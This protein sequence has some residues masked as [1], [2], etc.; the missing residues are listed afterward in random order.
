MK[1]REGF[2]K[3]S[4]REMHSY[5]SITFAYFR[6]VKSNAYIYKNNLTLAV[7]N[8]CELERAY[9]NQIQDDNR[10]QRVHHTKAKRPQTGN[11]SIKSR[12]YN[13]GGSYH[14]T[15]LF[16]NNA[17]LRERYSAFVIY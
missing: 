14:K 10:L 3:I 2:F 8:K 13:I 17:W 12:N 7:P 6:L 5:G 16:N 4:N 9:T 11:L 1:T 15:Y